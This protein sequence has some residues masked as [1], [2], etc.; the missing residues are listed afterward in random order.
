VAEEVLVRTVVAQVPVVQV[1]E[2]QGAMVAQH[3][4]QLTILAV[5]AGAVQLQ[6]QLGAME[7]QVLLLLD[8][9]THLQQRQPQVYLM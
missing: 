4:M 5:E 9:L 3:K 2:H 6:A 8:I 7:A 1:A